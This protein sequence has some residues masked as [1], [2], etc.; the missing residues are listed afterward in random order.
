MSTDPSLKSGNHRVLVLVGLNL[1]LL[2]LCLLRE[3]AALRYC[4]EALLLFLLVSFFFGQ[5]LGF[6][7]SS[8]FR[9]LRRRWVL[10]W[11]ALPLPALLVARV[12]AGYL[13]SHSEPLPFYLLTFLYLTSLTALYSSFLPQVIDSSAD[14]STA[15]ARA[16]SAELAGSL[17]G[18]LLLMALGS[19]QTLA[20]TLFYPGLL[21]LLAAWTAVSRPQ[22]GA[23]ALL[24]FGS[25]LIFVANDHRS[26]VAHYRLA[27]NLPLESRLVFRENSPYQKVEVLD[28]GQEKMLFLNGV[29][30]FS[31]GS[32]DHFNFYLSEVPARLMRPAKVLVI[33]SGSMSAVGRMSPFADSI[34]TVELDPA[35]VRA[36]RLHFAPTHPPKDY[37]HQVVIDDA[38]RFL[39][40]TDQRFDLIVL[41]VPTA[42]TL[43]TGTLFTR[44]FFSLAKSRLSPN[45]V[46]SL[47]LTQPISERLDYP[48]A[49][50]ILAA[51]DAEF[52]DYLLLTAHDASN[53]F[54]YASNER[55]PF[56][57]GSLDR[58]LASEKRFEQ[59]LFEE[60]VAHRIAK[61]FEPASLTNLEHVWRHQ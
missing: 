43:Q 56:D 50:P 48:V 7:L 14:R 36:S 3:F 18:V 28:T 59:Y 41:D 16:Y 37:D 26:V 25:S 32:L 57:R 30:F 6:L 8:K 54:V 31:E 10:V 19:H 9:C 38:R 12:L 46:V 23:L 49:G 5:S 45:G 27:F 60:D 61:K 21:L 34:T 33:G 52:S 47:Y 29:E 15:L 2:H 4:T 35:V 17:L 51:V 42:F 22:L 24:A 44:D 58:M 40:K 20:L 53:S 55:L 11:L 1:S 13:R 39:R